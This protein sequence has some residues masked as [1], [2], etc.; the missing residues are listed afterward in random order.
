[1]SSRILLIED[2]AANLDL[3]RYLL[4]S[5]GYEVLTAEDGPS[6]LAA[7]EAHRPDLVVCDVQIP[8]FD[9]LEL[10]RRV[11]AGP[12]A[13]IPLLAV[14]ALAMVGDRERILSAGFDGYLSKP[15][16][17]ERFPTEIARYLNGSDDDTPA[18]ATRNVG[19]SIEAPVVLVVDDRPVNRNLVRSLLEPSG[20]SVETAS[21]VAEALALLRDIPCRLI[22]SDIIMSGGS[23]YDLLR[24]VKAQPALATIPFVFLTATLSAPEEVARGIAMGATRYVVKP[25]EPERL[26]DIVRD[27]LDGC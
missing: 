7:V 6:G 23:G 16:A 20:Y 21:S 24:A 12:C 3:M 9:G 2:N 15:I 10:A 18:D 5:F 25:I 4:E 22:L 26:L 1:L 19:H 8:G 14:T 13:R 11:K 17:P 27:C